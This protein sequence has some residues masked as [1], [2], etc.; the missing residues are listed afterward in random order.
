MSEYV[1]LSLAATALAL[2]DSK[3]DALENYGDATSVILGSAHGSADFSSTYYREIVKQGL[4]GANPVLFAEGVP[5]SAAAHLSLMLAPER[6]M[7]DDH[8]LAY[9]RAGCA[10]PG[11]AA[12]PQRAVGSRDRGRRR[13]VQRDRQRCLRV[14]RH[15]QQCRGVAGE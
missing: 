13:G 8:R 6:R 4:V 12:N 5:N 2:K 1:K 14:L 10:S 3:L 9:E 11:S 15:V 7:P